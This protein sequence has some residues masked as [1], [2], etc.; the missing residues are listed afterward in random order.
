MV[1]ACKTDKMSDEVPIPRCPYA[2]HPW[3]SHVLTHGPCRRVCEEA[4]RCWC[5]QQC[6]PISDVWSV[7]VRSF[8]PSSFDYDQLWRRGL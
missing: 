1:L 7:D 3:L 5:C 6:Q 2:Q 8:L 4:L